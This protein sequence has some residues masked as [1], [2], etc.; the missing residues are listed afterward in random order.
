[1]LL[2]VEAL[3]ISEDKHELHEQK[4]L[5]I[6]LKLTVTHGAVVAA[7]PLSAVYFPLVFEFILAARHGSWVDVPIWALLGTFSVDA[8]AIRVVPPDSNKR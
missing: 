2:L 8:L 5:W 3:E 1:V 6:P 4:L 7:E